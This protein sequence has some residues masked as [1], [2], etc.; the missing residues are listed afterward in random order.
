M[1]GLDAGIAEV[2]GWLAA[3]RGVAV[4]TGAGVSAESRIPT[5]RTSPEELDGFVDDDEDGGAWDSMKA[6]WARFD[7]A[8]LA[9]PEAY[10]RDPA[11]VSRWYD[12]RRVMCLRAEPNPG[13]LALA[14]LQRAVEGRGGR[15]GLITQNVDGL[16]QRAGSTGVIELHG[17]IHA[18]RGIESGRAAAFGEGPIGEY[19]PTVPGSDEIARPGVVWFGEMLPDAAVRSAAA[20]TDEADVF[21][22][23]G[24]SAEVYPAAGFIGRARDAGAKTVEVNPE[25][26]AASREV[27][28]VLRG[29]GGEV[30]PKLVSRAV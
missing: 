29:A 21:L 4:L 19:P 11:M 25:A 22:T 13:H 26:T 28:V 2:R 17:S 6:L 1:D 27:D 3:A 23:I 18:W 10:R 30:M 16:H 14:A 12:W 7:P 9:T 15:F 20:V 5:F 24:T 8:T